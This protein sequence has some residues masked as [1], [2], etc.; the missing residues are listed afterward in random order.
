MGTK[1][2]DLTHAPSVENADLIP[3]SKVVGTTR[4][5]YNTSISELGDFITADVYDTI[6]QL[7]TTVGG[8]YLPLA[9]GTMKGDLDLDNN[10]IKKFKAFVTTITADTTLLSSHNGSIL[11]VEKSPQVLPDDRVLLTVPKDT[12]PIGFNVLIIQTGDI[13]AKIVKGDPSVTLANPD[14]SL[15]TRQKYSQINLCIIKNNFAWI[16]GDMV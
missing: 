13:Q 10:Y 4:N 9:G 15:S 14:N 16:T 5:T 6:S 1:I 8:A 12:L 2:V 7:T 11:M 3:L